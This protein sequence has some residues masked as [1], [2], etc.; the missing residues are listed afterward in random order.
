MIS[1]NEYAHGWCRAC[2]Y[3]LRPSFLYC[4]NCQRKTARF[5]V[6]R[7][8]FTCKECG[9]MSPAGDPHAASCGKCGSRYG[10]VQEGM[11]R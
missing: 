6:R 4:P 8:R 5:G 9:H 7:V 1:T 2:G 3:V 10:S 11:E